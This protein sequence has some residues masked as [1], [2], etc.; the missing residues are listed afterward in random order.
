MLTENAVAQQC[1]PTMILIHSST[2]AATIMLEAQGCPGQVSRL[3]ERWPMG[4][5]A[6]ATVSFCQASAKQARWEK[7][8]PIKPQG[9]NS[10]GLEKELDG[11]KPMGA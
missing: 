7:T 9:L 11:D 5:S 10:T 6:G 3:A 8:W 1:V 4:Q 2:N